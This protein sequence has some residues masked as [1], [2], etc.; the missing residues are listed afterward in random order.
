[1]SEV[2]AR[3]TEMDPMEFGSLMHHVLEKFATESEAARATDAEVIRGEFHR[4]LDQRL[5]AVFGQ[6]L[7]VP[8]MIQRESARQRLGWWAEM[9]AEERAKGWQIVA[10]ETRLSPEDDP[11]T[12]ADM[13]VSG[14]VDR[15]ERHEQ[16][17]IRLIDFKTYSPSAGPGGTSKSVEDYHLARIKRT[18]EPE[19]F[20]DWMR[21]PNSLGEE[22]RWKD[23]QLPLYRLA[24]ERR[25]PGEKIQTAYAT[26]GK[27]RR[28]I[29][30]DAW[31]EL[32]GS[33]LE[34]ARLCATSIIAAIRDRVFWPPTEKLTF[35]DD[36][37]HLFFGDP[38]KSVDPELI[39]TREAA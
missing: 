10:V 9:E 28:D 21:T 37:G 20:V 35:A 39:S 33:L 18:E 22:A 13:I 25:Y 26:L 23:L 14:V 19:S 5:Y 6:R 4:L 2:D 17:G 31:Q 27:T 12:F 3:S 1:M 34:S 16:H 7:T 24:M 32:E 29:S 11:W 8:V 38:L 15:V 30:L 36:F